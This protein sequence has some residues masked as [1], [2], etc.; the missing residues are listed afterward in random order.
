MPPRPALRVCVFCGSRL[1]H[2]HQWASIA[3]DVGQAIASRGWGLVYGAGR[4]GLMGTVAQA[5]IEEGG[6]VLGVI[7]EYLT[8]IE[9]VLPGI[10]ELYI[11][12]TMIERKIKMMEEAQAFL[13]LPGGIGTLE[14]FFEVWT[15]LQTGGHNK[16]IV[17]A[18]LEGYYDTL[19]GFV[20]EACAHGF[21]TQG[22][23][24]KLSVA[25]SLEQVFAMLDHSLSLTQS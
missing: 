3:A 17:L 20:K 14:E 10:H 7:P 9:P 25:S 16:P 23:L 1:G 15:G 5:A 19:L 13:V 22:H 21:L 11:V 2:H 6:Y 18:N 8:K 24:D 12:Q 4:W